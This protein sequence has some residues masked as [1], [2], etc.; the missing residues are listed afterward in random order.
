MVITGHGV[1]F[2]SLRSFHYLLFSSNHCSIFC[3]M[4]MTSVISMVFRSNQFD[5]LL[6]STI[7]ISVMD[8]CSIV[9]Y[10]VEMQ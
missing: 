5:K 8:V 6:Y 1:L 4:K 10:Y 3:V 2:A 7:Y 9:D